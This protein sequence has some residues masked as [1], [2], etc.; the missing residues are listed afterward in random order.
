MARQTRDQQVRTFVE[1][2]A[3]GTLALGVTAVSSAKIELEFAINHALRLWSCASQFPSL[4][5]IQAGNYV[6]IGIRKSERRRGARACWRDG[7]WLT[8][9][10]VMDGWSAD[11]CLQLLAELEPVPVEGWL[12][13]GRLFIDHLGD[14][15]VQ[16]EQ[17]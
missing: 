8:P 5:G 12:E 14:A 2:L 1:G 13:L 16:R 15:R 3:L 11:D 7:K 10:I 9:Y 6:W 17:G 4:S